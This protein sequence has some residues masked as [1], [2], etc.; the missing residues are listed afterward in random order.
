MEFIDLHI[1]TKTRL[2]QL[3][4]HARS[5]SGA[6]NLM[7]A[8]KSKGLEFPHVFVIGAIDSAWG[9]K[10]RSRSRRVIRYPANLQLQASGR[11]LRRA[12]SVVFC[13][14][15]SRQNHIDHDSILKP[16]ILAATR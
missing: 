11:Y 13:G 16:M 8:H 9:E 10:V 6:I 4:P 3:G 5:L 12:T 7:T 1:S 2:T 15:D 14:D